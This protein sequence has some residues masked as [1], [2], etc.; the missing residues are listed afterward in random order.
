[1][2]KKYTPHYK[3]YVYTYMRMD[4]PCLTNLKNI[5]CMLQQVYEESCMK[6]KQKHGM[7]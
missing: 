3:T 6:M 4:L 2:S 7:N 1:M 5:S